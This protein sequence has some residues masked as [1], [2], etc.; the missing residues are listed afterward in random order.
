M[1][2]VNARVRDLDVNTSDRLGAITFTATGL[3]GKVLSGVLGGCR[4]REFENTGDGSMVLTTAYGL[5]MDPS[6]ASDFEGLSIK[7][8][9]EARD[10]L[11]H[12]VSDSR[13]V[14]A[15]VAPCAAR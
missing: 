13:T 11:G 9:V 15:H 8:S 14:V 12:R 1:F 3:D 5:P 2:L 4:M 10:H 6:T 7:I